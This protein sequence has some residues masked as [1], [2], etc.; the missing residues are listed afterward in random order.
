MNGTYATQ[1][2]TNIGRLMVK[3]GHKVWPGLIPTD[4]YSKTL[5]REGIEQGSDEWNAAQQ[6][7]G[8]SFVEELQYQDQ[9]DHDA[10]LASLDD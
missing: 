7:A 2:G 3:D 5:E 4:I 6:A 8:E 1:L 9:R 10:Y